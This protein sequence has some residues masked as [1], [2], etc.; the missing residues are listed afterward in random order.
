MAAAGAAAGDGLAMKEML[1]PAS[2][3][4]GVETITGEGLAK[5]SKAENLVTSCYQSSPKSG[6]NERG[7]R[8]A[9]FDPL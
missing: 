8:D 1:R 2:L 3:W 9:A 4:I 7:P 5:V 6:S